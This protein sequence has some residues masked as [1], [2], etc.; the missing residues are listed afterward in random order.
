MF[1]TGVASFAQEDDAKVIL[2]SGANTTIYNG[3]SLSTAIGAAK[4]GD[5]IYLSEGTYTGFT[6]DKEILVRGVGERT[7]IDGDITIAIPDEPTMT[8]PVLEGVRSGDVKITKSATDMVIRNCRLTNLTVSAALPNGLIDRCYISNK[9]YLNAFTNTVTVKNTKI[10][11]LTGNEANNQCS[12]RNCN[13]YTCSGSAKFENCILSSSNSLSSSEVTKCAMS[14]YYTSTTVVN[15]E[16]YFDNY[17]LNSKT[18]ESQYDLVSLNYLGTD[19]TVIGVYGGATP[20]TLDP[21]VAKVTEAS[22][23]VDATTK[24]LTVKLKVA[25]K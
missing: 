15:G 7:Y 19:G 3:S 1:M 21:Q 4:K 6:I 25:A 14:Q 17:S 13:I 11:E 16:C 18:L 9:M 10:Y 23:N 8:T 24:K 12:F 5:I 2:Q 20:F 22:F